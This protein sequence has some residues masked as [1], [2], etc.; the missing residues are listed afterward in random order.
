MDVYEMDAASESGVDDVREVIVD[1]A[2]YK[3][4]I[5]RYKVF[6]IDEVHDLSGKACGTQGVKLV[7]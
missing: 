4:T 5:A 3:P 7:P 6:I 2:E 1:V